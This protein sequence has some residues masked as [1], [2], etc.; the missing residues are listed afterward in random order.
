ML[1]VTFAHMVIWDLFRRFIYTHPS[2]CG[3]CAKSVAQARHPERHAMKIVFVYMHNKFKFANLLSAFRM[4]AR[5]RAFS[6]T[7]SQCR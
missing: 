3:C 2:M 4:R 7:R 1:H 6:D 5:D